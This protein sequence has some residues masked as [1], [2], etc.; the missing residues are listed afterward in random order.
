[1]RGKIE[2]LFG[3]GTKGVLLFDVSFLGQGRVVPFPI[4]RPCTALEPDGTFYAEL[5]LD[6]PIW[7]DM[8][9][10]GENTAVPFYIRPGDTL[11]IT[12]KGMLE[13]DVTVDYASSHPEAVMR[14][15]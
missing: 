12:V 9:L 2:G 11:D 5:S 14:T 8:V 3:I 4:S 6:H 13:K 10:G 15:C 7:A 1:M